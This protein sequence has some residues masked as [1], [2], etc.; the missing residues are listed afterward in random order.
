MSSTC[1]TS[2]KEIDKTNIR[3]L[4]IDGG[5][6]KGIIPVTALQYLEKKSG[7]PTSQLFD[8]FAGT[9][10]GAMIVAGLNLPNKDNKPRFS[11]SSILD[12]YLNLS[13]HI[14]SI[15]IIRKIFT[16]NGLLGPSYSIK[17][18]HHA[19]ELSL[20]STTRFNDLLN[21]VSIS[22]FNFSTKKLHLFNN[23]ECSKDKSQYSV[24]DIVSS[25]VATPGYFSPV[26]L[27]K[28][29][30][31]KDNVFV[32]SVILANDPIIAALKQ[33]FM[34]YPNAK[35]FTILHLGT[36]EDRLA[37][38]HNI[39]YTKNGWG[40]LREGLPILYLFYKFR[41][42]SIHDTIDIV[43]HFN[44]ESN[45]DYHY[46]NVD[47]YP[48]DPFDISIKGIKEIRAAATKLIKNNQ[49]ELDNLAEQLSDN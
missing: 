37:Y 30:N 24:A 6:I 12:Y 46:I 35:K 1:T 19:L 33:A 48:N 27:K 40:V 8:Y 10:T 41:E 36:G 7:Q 42:R 11:A 47:M 49:K 5:G 16:L 38:F 9:S 44:S 25:A 17:K 28:F 13:T 23:W 3:I 29:T 2:S 32:D 15:D 14:L 20:D 22:S 18:M 45:I 43:Q 26:I 21:M 4:V 31:N 34:L 39:G